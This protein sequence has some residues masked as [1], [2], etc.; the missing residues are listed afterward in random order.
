MRHRHNNNMSVRVH[1]PHSC[2]PPNYIVTVGIPM[3]LVEPLK[4]NCNLSGDTLV[5]SE[6]RRLEFVLEALQQRCVIAVL[7]RIH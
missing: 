2:L 5:Q 6:R 3:L 1:V 7:Y 4:R